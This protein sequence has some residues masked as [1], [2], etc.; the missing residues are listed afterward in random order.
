MPLASKCTHVPLHPCRQ[1][2]THVHIIKDRKKTKI[3]KKEYP[4][5]H[6]DLQVEEL[7]NDCR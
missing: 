1:T 7:M 5:S 2:H 6:K 4:V 3:K